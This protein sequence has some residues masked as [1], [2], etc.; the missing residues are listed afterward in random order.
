ML[1]RNYIGMNCSVTFRRIVLERT[2]GVD[3]GLTCVEDYVLYLRVT[4]E[5]PVACHD[6]VVAH[7]RRRPDAMSRRTLA[8]LGNALCVLHG[9]RPYLNGGDGA[10]EA[11]DAGL[12][13]WKEFYGEQ[14]SRDI[15]CRVAARRWR[16]ASRSYWWRVG[17]ALGAEPPARLQLTARSAVC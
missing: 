10:G 12:R 17:V 3:P 16:E 6:K 5:H 11:Y 14:L 15:R 9:Q 8:M 13:F 7:Y 4:R 1:R 2:G